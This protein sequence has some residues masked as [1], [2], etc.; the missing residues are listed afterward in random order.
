[1]ATVNVSVTF[2]HTRPTDALKRYAA[3]K[4]QKIGRHLD[5][6]LNAHVVLAVDAKNRQLAEMTLQA[7]RTT[8]HGCEETADLYVAID[9]AWE[10]IER[11]V[12]KQKTKA[13][14]RRRKGSS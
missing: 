8:F 1:M 5:G 10:K 9:R 4:V 7:R 13:K 12:V 2:R 3:R 11:Q 6:P 14:L